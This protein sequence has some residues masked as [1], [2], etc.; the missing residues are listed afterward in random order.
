MLC[1]PS[2]DSSNMPASKVALLWQHWSNQLDALPDGTS[3]NPQAMPTD[4]ACRLLSSTLTIAICYYY[5]APH[6][7]H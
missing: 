1:S 3:V 4:V 7:L 2:L 5:Y 6:S